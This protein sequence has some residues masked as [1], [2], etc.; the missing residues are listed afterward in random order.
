MK[1]YIITPAMGKRLIGMA[2]ANHPD[3]QRVLVKGSLVIIG[4]STNGYVAEEVLKSIGQSE[5][6]SKAGF[7][8]GLVAPTGFDVPKIDFPGDVFIQD[9]EWVKGRTI[10]DVV[11]GLKT[12]DM[13]VKGANVFDNRRQA[14]VHIGGSTGGTILCALTAIIGRRVGLMVPV[15]LEKRVFEDVNEIAARCNAPGASGPRLMPL[16]GKTFTEIDAIKLLTGAGAFLISAGGVYG[17]EGAVRLGISG[18]EGQMETAG[19]LIDSLIDE[20]ACEV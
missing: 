14:A 17:A 11:D 15:G 1:Q 16:P 2:I 7:R 8:R 9:G 10:F 5:G 12:G 19:N 20:P 4:G 13:V 3:I 18:D 6:F